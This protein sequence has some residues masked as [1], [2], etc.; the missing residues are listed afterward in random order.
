MSNQDLAV[1]MPSGG[2][3]MSPEEFAQMQT[4]AKAFVASGLFTDVKD[5]AQAIVKMVAGHELKIPPFSA[6]KGI[7]FIQIGGK[8]TVELSANLRGAI[9]Q[10]SGRYTYRLRVLSPTECSI[11]FFERDPVS[12]QFESVGMSTYTWEQATSARLTGKDVWKQYPEDMLF[13]SALRK[14]ARRHCPDLFYG[15]LSN[16]DDDLAITAATVAAERGEDAVPRLGAQTSAVPTIEE[17]E[18]R[19]KERRIIMLC[20]ELGW[21]D[22]QRHAAAAEL[23]GRESLTELTD[24]ELVEFADHLKSFNRSPEGA[25]GAGPNDSDAKAP[26]RRDSSDT[27]S[28]SSGD[29]PQG[30][31]AEADSRSS[32]TPDPDPAAATA[33]SDAGSALVPSIEPYREADGSMPS[34]ADT[35]AELI[36]PTQ[37]GMIYKAA[38]S[39]AAAEQLF[40]ARYGFELALA[41]HTQGT[42]FNKWLRDP[43]RAEASA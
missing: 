11:E 3:L 19:R 21:S 23:Y 20:R 4:M 41:K 24:E 42:E 5:Q 6:M 40:R 31:T 30:K 18:R 32:T 7:H 26:D 35:D 27:P 39:Q 16:D 13:A 29:V 33:Q 17:Q 8:A 36:K 1:R 43:A 2:S 15:D 28:A 9:I 14:G 38:G 37:L 22:D 34:P 12:D 10:R 25:Q